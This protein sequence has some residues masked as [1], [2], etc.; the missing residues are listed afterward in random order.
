MPNRLF[1]IKYDEDDYITS[2]I[3]DF[4]TGVR[5]TFSEQMGSCEIEK[6]D[7]R[8][9]IGAAISW[10][11]EEF[12]QN[13]KFIAMR[14]PAQFFD[15]HDDFQYIGMVSFILVGSKLSQVVFF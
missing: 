12:I 3:H 4:N 14:N 1:H 6:L 2:E 5:Y 7:F 9:E 15:I 13:G 10:A 8:G 11:P